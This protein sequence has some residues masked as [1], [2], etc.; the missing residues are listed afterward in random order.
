[1][2]VGAGRESSSS[3]DDWGDEDADGLFDG[4]ASLADS[5]EVGLGDDSDTSGGFPGET[6]GSEES[7][8]SVEGA[9]GL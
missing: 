1:M 8:V 2:L 3:G 7:V 6:E 4:K 9:G 5:V